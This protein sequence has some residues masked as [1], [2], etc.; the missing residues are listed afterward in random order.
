MTE[1]ADD[2]DELTR[3]SSHNSL[4]LFLLQQHTLIKDFAYFKSDPKFLKKV[5]K[6][7]YI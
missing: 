1:M 3:G 6:P 7:K 5:S 2:S 4:L